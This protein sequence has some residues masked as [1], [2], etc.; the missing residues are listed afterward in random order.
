[1]Q[2]K[3]ARIVAVL[4]GTVGAGL[5]MAVLGAG[6]LMRA[7]SAVGLPSNF[8]SYSCGDAAHAHDSY[9]V[10][11]DPFGVVLGILLSL[12]VGFIVARV[13]LRSARR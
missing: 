5:V 4:V 8:R 12:L 3:Q 2:S 6:M 11:V 7:C 1:M 9:L 13:F 10:V